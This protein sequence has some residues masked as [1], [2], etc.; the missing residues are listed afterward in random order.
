LDTDQ[1]PVVVPVELDLQQASRVADE[2][3]KRNAGASARFRA[4]RK[5]KEKE[6]SDTISGLQGELRDLMAE[7]DFYMAERNYFRDLVN[8]NALGGQILP[9]PLSPRLHRRR[10]T[11][12]PGSSSLQPL[13]DDL[14]RDY[15]EPETTQRR[16]TG[17][18][19][20]SFVGVQTQSPTTSVYTMGFPSAPPLPPPPA[21]PGAASFTPG[22]LPPGPP[23][24]P[25]VTRSQS[26]D[27]FRRSPYDQSWNPGR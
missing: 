23:P 19:D 14:Y 5:E 21:L 11:S 10:V 16:R 26:Y 3:R 7:R 18:Y 24:Q 20:T 25:S 1:G 2:K 6:A 15:S 17:D 8:R 4:R 27:P 9:R 13:S 12:A 22:A